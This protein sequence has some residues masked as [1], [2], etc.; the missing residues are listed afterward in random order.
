M[1]KRDI[2]QQIDLPFLDG[3]I[4]DVA[5]HSDYFSGTLF[6]NPLAIKESLPDGIRIRPQ[7]VGNALKMGILIVLKYPGLTAL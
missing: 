3:V 5:H 6:G 4:P 7:F 1:T 2:D